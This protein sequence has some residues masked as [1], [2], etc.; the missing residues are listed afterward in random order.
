MKPAA[1]TRSTNRQSSGPL[2]MI[3][4]PDRAA[5]FAAACAALVW[6]LL[7]SPANVSAQS[8][9]QQLFD[10]VPG[11]SGKEPPPKIGGTIP[12]VGVEGIEYSE[13]DGRITL[14][15]RD[16]PLSKVISLLAQLEQLNIVAANDIDAIISITLHNVPIEEALTAI[17]DVAN[18]TWVRRNDIILVTSLTEAAKLPAD[19]QG[20]QIRVFELNFAS[21]TDVEKV[22]NTAGFLSPVGKISI[23]EILSTDNRRTREMVVVEDLP[24]SIERVAQYIAQVDQPP[25]QVLI[26]AHLL[27]VTLDDETRNGVNFD[28]LFRVAG[29]TVNVVSIPSAAMFRAPGD[30]LPTAPAMLATLGSNDLAALID[31]LQTTT[32]S[33]TLGSPKLLVLNG[34]EA[35]IQIGQTIYYS[36]IT[37]TQTSSQQGAGS[38]ETGVILR[39]MPRITRDGRVLL[40]VA[41]EVSAAGERSSPELPPDTSKTALETDVMLVDGQGVVIGGLIDERDST[42]QSKVPWLGNLKGVGW[43]FRHTTVTKDRKEIIVA[44]IPRIQ[45]YEPQYQAYEQGELVRTGVP[46][47]HGPLERTNRPWDPIL[48]DGR[49]V[50]MPLRPRKAIE[51]YHGYPT[52]WPPE[53]RGYYVPSYPMPQQQFGEPEGP[54]GDLPTPPLRGPFLSDE[55]AMMP[56]IS[57][58]PQQ[59]GQV[60]SDQK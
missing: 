34:Q 50:T 23:N 15:V 39:I 24:D 40:K 8:P 29:A 52:G 12:P 33:K 44:L 41:P 59:R 47:F 51:Y 20:R 11:L 17:L 9:L 7:V 13:K 30:P 3:S 58:T 18:Y 56:V 37:T 1:Q 27:E 53:S 49:R 5:P 46:L 22:I 42:S 14:I 6:L 55:A 26:E 38:I 35:R 21:A 10:N 54:V 43:L 31:L 57:D 32:D 60:I 28:A 36:Q 25:Q 4:R 16:Q 48:P 45:P 2:R 19:A